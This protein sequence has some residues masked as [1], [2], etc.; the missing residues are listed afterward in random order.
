MENGI[1]IIGYIDLDGIEQK[2]VSLEPDYSTDG[3]EDIN[4]YIDDDS[5]YDDGVYEDWTDEMRLKRS[6]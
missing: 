4:D 3:E 5:P 6:F 1:K 2:Y